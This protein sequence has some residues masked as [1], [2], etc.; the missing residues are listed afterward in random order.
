[1][2]IPYHQFNNGKEL[3]SF[4]NNSDLIGCKLC[5]RFLIL[6]DMHM[7]FMNGLEMATQIRQ[8]EFE[9][10]NKIVLITADE[11]PENKLFDS[12]IEKPLPAN[13]L[14]QI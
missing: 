4:L 12:I 1:M 7:P 9:K 10:L 8:M 6:T 14:K 5:D 11:I 2:K 3:I 13:K